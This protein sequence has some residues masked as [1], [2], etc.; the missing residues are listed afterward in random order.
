MRSRAAASCLR[1]LFLLTRGLILL[2]TLAERYPG[3]AAL[4]AHI[5]VFP[6]RGAILLRRGPSLPLQVFEPR[7]LAMLEDAIAGHRLIGILQPD[8]G[9]DESPAGK[10]NALRKVGCV[11]THRRLP[12]LDDGRLLITLTGIARFDVK[13]RS[14]APSPTACSRS[15]LHASR[16]TSRVAAKTIRRPAGLAEGAEDVS[17]SRNLRID[18][19]AGPRA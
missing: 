10:S 16:L 8:G 14:R 1:W 6:L 15:M 12:E 13:G 2:P 17:R 4:P 11:G 19:S 9:A 5:P 3:P 7:Y 18:W